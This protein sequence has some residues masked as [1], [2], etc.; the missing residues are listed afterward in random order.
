M[1]SAA[2]GQTQTAQ[3]R[4]SMRDCKGPC[5]EH[6]AYGCGAG[7]AALAYLA[8]GYMVASVVYLIVTRPL[9]TPFSD[10]LTDAQRAIL[11]RSKGD[12]RRAFGIGVL[13]A[14]LVLALLRPIRSA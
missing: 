8:L 11:A 7:T 12:R 14:A 10:S 2:W 4:A 13:V 3:T 5:L 9:G 6:C 1:F